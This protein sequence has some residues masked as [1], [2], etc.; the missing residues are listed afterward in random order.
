MRRLKQIALVLGV[1]F[2][3]IQLVPYGRGHDNP[4]VV[5]GPTWDS[6]E[7][8]ALARRACFDCHSNETTW[9]WYSHVA[10][11]SWLVQHDVEDGRKHLNFSRFDQ[12]QKH[13]HEAGEEVEEGEM[14]M[15]I[16]LVTHPE[17]RLTDA[18]TAA[19]V[20]GL[21]KTLGKKKQKGQQ[22]A[23]GSAPAAAGGG[24]SDHAHDEGAGHTHD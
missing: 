14:P 19:L 10:P 16:Y 7:T 3:A 21:N 17:A 9:P 2:V 22:A 5:Q 24:D 11:V 4:A 18:E 12:P 13:A 15:K 8:E 23:A 6:P 1:L 20:A